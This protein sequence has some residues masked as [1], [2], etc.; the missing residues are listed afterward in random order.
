MHL[1]GPLTAVALPGE[2]G[3]CYRSGMRWSPHLVAAFALAPIA[4]GFDEDSSSAT[5]ASQ[6]Q[7]G[8]GG[9]TGGDS[10]EPTGGLPPGFWPGVA[11]APAADEQAEGPKIYFDLDA[12]KLDGRDYF[13]LPFPLDARRS[14]SGID[15]TG[16][17]SPP[18]DL[19]PEFGA[20][21]ARWLKYLAADAPGFAVNSATLFRSTHGVGV[22]SGIFYINLT[23]G[24]PDYGKKLSGLGYAAQNGDLSGNN[25]ICRNWLAV[26]TIDGYPLEPNTT[27]GVLLSDAMKPVGG[28]DF[29]ADVDFTLMLRDTPPADPVRLSAWT[30]FAPLRAF[31][32][33]PENSAGPAL[34]AS[35]LIGGAVFTTAPNRDVL[36]GAREA[37]RDAPLYVSD[38]HLCTA[39]GDGPCSTAPGLTDEERA[40]RR[41][42]PPSPQYRE[43][44]GRIRLPIFQEGVAPYASIGG[45]IDL[46]DGKPVQ[47]SSVDACFSLTLP[48]TPTPDAGW[49][50]LI[51]AHGTGGSFRSAIAQ[52]VAPRL[53]AAGVA[54]IAVEGV[55][56]GERRGDTDSDGEVEGLDVDQLVFNVLNPES[57]RD[58]MVQGAIDQ[59]SAVRLA[60]QWSDATVLAGEPIRFDPTALFYMGHSQGANAG[61][62]F[63]PYE[64]L[65]RA[66]VLSGGGSN[67]LRALLG[68]ENPKVDVGGTLLAPRE[69]LQL[70]FQERPD[71][72]LTTMHPMLVLLNTFVNRSDADNTASLLRRRPLPGAAARHLLN[73]LGH[74]D[75]YA[76]LRSAGS[77]AI[78]AGAPIA[79]ATIFP[80]PCDQYSEDEAVA[81]GWTTGQWLPTTAM[82]ATK[83]IGGVTAVTR[84]LRAP[85]GEDGHFVAFAPAELERIA[86]FIA[87]ALANDAPTVQ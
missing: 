59:F 28:G 24:H 69:L 83:N 77:L 29:T 25:Y 79:G 38:L 86:Q 58:T 82:P 26:E 48:T 31:L 3:R 34:T 22:P 73:Y 12:G 61:A 55:H 80:P 70:A 2:P 33:S 62:L 53:A 52:G 9:T 68:K 1:H 11:C 66:V 4:C 67:L 30:T 15:L 14:G 71:R 54:T 16:F 20:V 39:A 63:L 46:A 17:P 45:R 13:R 8:G 87:S 76:P 18:E 74:V 85:A 42:G 19:D 41:C 43:V 64:P 72:P 84:M 32:K 60:E 65:V 78:G 23:P 10:G 40:D 57:A 6:G 21:V 5:A 44:Q 81:C 49:P 50:A 37:A 51:F 36:A 56:H 75:T 35:R 47:R 7:S 27:Y